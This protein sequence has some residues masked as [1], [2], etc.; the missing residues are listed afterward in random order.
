MD[1]LA[2]SRVLAS[3]FVAIACVLFAGAYAI[4]VKGM[5]FLVAGYDP[6]LVRDKKGLARWMGGGLF[7][8]GAVLLSLASLLL[9]EPRLWP[10]AIGAIPAVGPVGAGILVAGAQ[11]YRV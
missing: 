2:A 5:L 7:G 1:T 10:V 4:G 6:N 8:I 11:R 9:L 3:F